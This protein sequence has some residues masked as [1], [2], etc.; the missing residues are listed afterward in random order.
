MNPKLDVNFDV[1]IHSSLEWVDASEVQSL[2]SDIESFLNVDK[3]IN[4]VQT[5]LEDK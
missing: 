1:D 4:D 2:V 5:Y 3:F